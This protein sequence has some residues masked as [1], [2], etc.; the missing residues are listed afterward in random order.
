[1]LRPLQ[2]EPGVAIRVETDLFTA[3]DVDGTITTNTNTLDP[4]HKHYRTTR[5]TFPNP[6]KPEGQAIV[7]L[8][9]V[10]MQRGH[11]GAGYAGRGAMRWP[12]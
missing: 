2:T 10:I 1:M 7:P 11:V 6:F 5:M 8:L 9:V 12:M 4:A 3:A